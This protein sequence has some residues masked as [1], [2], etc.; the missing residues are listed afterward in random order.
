M[1]I[2]RVEEI[3]RLDNSSYLPD[4]SLDVVNG[5]EKTMETRQYLFQEIQKE[6]HEERRKLLAA[7]DKAMELLEEQWYSGS[8]CLK[9]FFVLETVHHH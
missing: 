9:S 4:G 8:K 3:G 1:N 5:Y 6:H 2:I 7:H